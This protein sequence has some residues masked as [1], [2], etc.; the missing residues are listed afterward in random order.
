MSTT[1]DT[2][3]VKTSNTGGQSTNNTPPNAPDQKE[4]IKWIDISTDT[5]YQ[6]TDEVFQNDTLKYKLLEG[7]DTEEFASLSNINPCMFFDSNKIANGFAYSK[8][9]VL[10]SDEYLPANFNL[11]EVMDYQSSYNWKRYKR[12]LVRESRKEYLL[13]YDKKYSELSADTKTVLSS[14]KNIAKIISYSNNKLKVGFKRTPTF[15]RDDRDT[16]VEDN[17]SD[18]DTDD[19]RLIDIDYKAKTQSLYYTTGLISEAHKLLFTP[20]SKKPLSDYKIDKS[21]KIVVFMNVS[22]K[23]KKY[24]LTIRTSRTIIHDSW[25]NDVPH[26][27]PSIGIIANT[28]EYV[29]PFLYD[30]GYGFYINIGPIYGSVDVNNIDGSFML[31]FKRSFESGKLVDQYIRTPFIPYSELPEKDE[32][33]VTI[34]T[35]TKETWY[36][37]YYDPF[38]SGKVISYDEYKKYQNERQL[39]LGGIFPTVLQDLLGYSSY[40]SKYNTAAHK[41]NT[42]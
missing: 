11:S 37:R 20:D 4:S 2:K 22:N 9:P 14:I 33:E 19:I 10:Y 12:W 15:I 34:N 31:S 40:A 26:L 38:G 18:D 42:K 24:D 41:P 13:D 7:V 27:C 1:G 21:V 29:A 6:E 39:A 30:T 5:A 25:V 17:D 3:D 23:S 35:S 32:Y 8:Y 36:V 16:G 28:S